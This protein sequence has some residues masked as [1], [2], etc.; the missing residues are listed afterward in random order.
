MKIV[1]TATLPRFSTRYLE[2]FQ[3]LKPPSSISGVLIPAYSSNQAT[4]AALIPNPDSYTITLSS[5][6]RPSRPSFD[7]RSR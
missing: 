2:S 5:P 1:G 4:R 6:L 7:S 3:A